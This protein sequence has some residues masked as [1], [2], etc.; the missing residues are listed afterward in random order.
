MKMT[1]GSI[2]AA[3]TIDIA[4]A[5]RWMLITANAIAIGAI[6]LPIN[7]ENWAANSN[8][9]DRS[10]SGSRARDRRTGASTVG[11]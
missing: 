9:N 1:V 11:R 8:R 5:E 7:D 10:R 6:P 4:E 2:L 3:S